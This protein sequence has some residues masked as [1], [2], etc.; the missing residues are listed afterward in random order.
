MFDG[1]QQMLF[2]E[3]FYD[4]SKEKIKN[5]NDAIETINE[6][7]FVQENDKKIIVIVLRN[8]E[9]LSKFSI[10][11]IRCFF[12]LPKNSV[13]TLKYITF[14]KKPWHL[15]SEKIG[16]IPFA[17]EVIL[18]PLTRDETCRYLINEL[19]NIVDENIE[20]FICIF[21]S[22]VWIYCVDFN[23]LLFLSKKCIKE[24][25]NRNISI[26]LKHINQ[27]K[28]VNL[29]ICNVLFSYHYMG[30]KEDKEKEYTIDL[31]IVSRYAIVASYCASFNPPT[32]DKRFFSS[33]NIKQ[34]KTL[35]DVKRDPKNSL[36]ELGP[37]NFSFDRFKMIFSFLLL[38]ADDIDVTKIGTI[39]T[40]EN[41]CNIG[42][43]GRSTK[44][45]NFDL[46]KYRSIIS[47]EFAEIVALS[48]NIP[49]ND[50]LFDFA[51][52]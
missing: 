45:T 36:H 16:C 4:L 6:R 30:K 3:I 17:M 2:R 20:K 12:E 10:S 35:S 9:D 41:L 51:S 27:Q 49:L 39:Q 19:K 25:Q 40:L 24:C 8:C 50:Y 5:C 28:E 43:L 52:L 26:A 21:L 32:S 38:K 37:K 7:K 1:E 15:I 48:I 34:R 13:V 18:N 46:P 44:E 33:G 14:S 23:Q 29:I 42:L 11:F 22:I 31:P 47:K